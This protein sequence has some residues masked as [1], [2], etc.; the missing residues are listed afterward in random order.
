MPRGFCAA[1]FSRKDTAPRR[2]LLL[3]GERPGARRKLFTNPAQLGTRRGVLP[4]TM[5]NQLTLL[6]LATAG[7]L[8]ATTHLR[9]EDPVPPTPPVNPPAGRPAA[10]IREGEPGQGRPNRPGGPRGG[11]RLEMMKERLNLTPEQVEKLKPIFAADAEKLKALR[12]DAALTR[13]QKGEKARAIV[14]ASMEEVKAILTPDQLEK[15]KAAM[16]KRKEEF[17]KRRA[18]QKE[19]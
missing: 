6:A 8:A 19:K 4:P 10:G 15:W 9:A 5:K 14:Q 1:E 16:E 2:V 3:F 18:E 13:E 11:D 12:E 17:E 7:L